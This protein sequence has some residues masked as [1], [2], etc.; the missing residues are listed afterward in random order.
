MIKTWICK[1]CGW[2]W[3]TLM[4]DQD[5]EYEEQCPE[6]HSFDTEESCIK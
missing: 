5:E 3:T 4:E 6:C 2:E 1:E